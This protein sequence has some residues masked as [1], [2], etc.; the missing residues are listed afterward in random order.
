MPDV[1][2][3]ASAISAAGAA[4]SAIFAGAQIKFSR[5]DE[6]RRLAFEHLREVET[7]LQKTWGFATD[8]MQKEVLDYYRRDRRDLTEGASAILALLNSLDLLAYGLE[9][10][11]IDSTVIDEWVKT[12][13]SENVL[14]QTFLRELQKCCGDDASYEH[15]YKYF[16]KLR[17]VDREAR[18]RKL[19]EG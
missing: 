19:K 14:S 13:V 11:L 5:R 2:L 15:L 6:N 4:L 16:T 1:A 7:R 10:N 8:D 12:V 3:V 17:A 9:K 18:R